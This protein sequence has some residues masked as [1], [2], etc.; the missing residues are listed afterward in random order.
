MTA[1]KKNK[2]LNVIECFAYKN[3]SQCFLRKKK[4]FV[5]AKSLNIFLTNDTNFVGWADDLD[6]KK[7]NTWWQFHIRSR[8]FNEPEPY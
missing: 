4:V 1:W 8:Q 3:M 2:Y 7:E 6:C 5:R